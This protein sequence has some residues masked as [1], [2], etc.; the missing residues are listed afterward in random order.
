MIF[1]V[2]SEENSIECILVERNRE[3][4]IFITSSDIVF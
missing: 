4:V 1:H 3:L 2:R